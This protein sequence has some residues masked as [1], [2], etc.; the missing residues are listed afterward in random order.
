MS[1]IWFDVTTI[2]LWRRPATGVVRVEAE[3]FRHLQH[4]K[5]VK[6]CSFDRASGQYSERNAAEILETLERNAA[7]VAAPR[8]DSFTRRMAAAAD[9]ALRQA[10]L[11]VFKLLS[12]VKKASTPVFR[13]ALHRL[14]ETSRSVQAT[15]QARR[16]REE[17]AR[18]GALPTTIFSA[19]DVL[20]SAGL[21]WDF[22]DLSLLFRL[23]RQHGF[24]VVLV[25]YD[26]IPVLFPHLCRAEVAQ[27]F[28]SYYADIAWVADH[29]LCISKSSQRDF[30]KY[31]KQIGAPLPATS[32][33]KLG[34]TPDT[35]GAAAVDHLVKGPFVL[36]VSTLERRKNHEILYRALARLADEGKPLPTLVFAGMRGWG[37]DD[38]LNDVA[39][40]PRVRGHIVQLNH[41]TDAELRGLYAS[42]SFT[43]FPSLYEGW[44]LPVAESFSHGRFCLAADTSSLREVGGTLAE[45]LDPWDVT[46][47]AERLS[48]FTDNPAELAKR[49]K[50]IA[51][52]FSPTPWSET[53]G[54]VLAVGRALTQR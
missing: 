9:G 18:S 14:R 17:E 8:A 11:P 12:R 1:T 47:W 38:L 26:L 20:V 5:G 24:K 2:L 21:D 25:C 39:R 49:E 53:A 6:F 28:P 43:V 16:A 41:V 13:G 4:E 46:S 54:A 35:H 36:F 33:V 45:Y 52:N 37:V 27:V 29:V 15:R 44:G 50:R 34:S 31:V 32:L 22:K 51:R 23:K 10:P 19:D 42:A 7:G 48:F 3:I 30:M 40:D